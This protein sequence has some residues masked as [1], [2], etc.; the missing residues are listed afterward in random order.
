LLFERVEQVAVSDADRDS[1]DQKP[2]QE[3]E[4]PA[5]VSNN[6]GA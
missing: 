3:A 2:R 1:H 6:S 5:G 4:M